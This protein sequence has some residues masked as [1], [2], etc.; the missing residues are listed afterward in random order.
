LEKIIK[1]L[2]TLGCTR[3]GSPRNH[4]RDRGR[5][6]KVMHCT[7]SQSGEK[8]RTQGEMGVKGALRLL[9]KREAEKHRGKAVTCASK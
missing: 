9:I 1:P 2:S 8:E 4:K 5:R 7:K 3:G 6:E